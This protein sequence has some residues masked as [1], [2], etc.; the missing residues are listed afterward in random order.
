MTQTLTGADIRGFYSALGIELP[1]RARTDASVRCFAAPEE[2][3]RNDRVP[4]CSINLVHGA[5]HCHACGASGGAFD[6]AMA[7]G[8]AKREAIALMV[9][10]GLTS[11]RADGLVEKGQGHRR[12]SARERAV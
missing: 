5:W 12:G 2:H 9:S 7:R 4:S 8:Y 6:A 1:A 11:H 10:H 3:R